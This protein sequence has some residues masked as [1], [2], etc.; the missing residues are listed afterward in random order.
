M[1][2]IS[3]TARFT[4]PFP[5]RSRMTSFGRSVLCPLLPSPLVFPFTN[6][7]S[8]TATERR[9]AFLVKSKWITNA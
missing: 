1:G 9:V 5:I 3:R 2:P 7:P 8:D 4:S 6:P